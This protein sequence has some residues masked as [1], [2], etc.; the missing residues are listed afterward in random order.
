MVTNGWKSVRVSLANRRR[1]LAF[2]GVNLSVLSQKLFTARTLTDVGILRPMRPDKL[3]RVADA[4]RRWGP[5]P[6]AGYTISAIRHPNQLAIIDELGRLTFADVHRRTNALAHALADAGVGEGD[7]VA[8]MCRNHRGF[9]DAV[10]ATSKLGANALYLN[11]A[12]AG[13]QIT[14]VVKREKPAALI[15]DAEFEELTHDAGARRKRFIAWHD[16]GEQPKDPL[17]EELIAS[18]DTSDVSPPAEKGRVVILTSGTTG[19]PKGAQRKQPE[20][21]DPAAA[22]FSKIPLHANERTLIAAPMFHS[23]GFVHF[24]LGMGLGSTLVLRRKF[25]PEDTLSAVAQ[26]ECTALIVVPVMLQRILELPAETIEKYDLSALRVVA[27]SGSALPGEMAIKLMDRFGDVLYN[28]YGS[29]EV[30]WATIATPQD[31]RAAPGTAGRPPRGTVV[32]LLDE[33]GNEVAPGETGRIFVGNEMAFE[34]YT[35]GGG[36]QNVGGLLSSGDV[37]HFDAAGR[38][39]IDGRDDEMIVSGGENVFP[40]EVEDLLHDHES[41]DEVAVI[42]VEDEQFGQRLKAFVV[43]CRGSSVGDD[44]LKDY[45]RANLARYKVPREIVFLDELPR[46][47]TGKV[48]KREL[49]ERG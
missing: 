40:R 27:A 26:H 14:D 38:L 10:V 34:G 44:E 39:F 24:T 42:G 4:L 37:G 9:V 7:G 36:K 28:L 35:G 25:D 1:L 47:A 29:T 5:T 43:R 2:P 19:A 41:I 17:L 32:K 6:A 18:G 12:F 30:A 33:Q 13:P 8:I 11:T 45:V 21:L 22:L 3:L 49:A 23:W 46:N 20:S 16:G 31:L 48:L 15:Y